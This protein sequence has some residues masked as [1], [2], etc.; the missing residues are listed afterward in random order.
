MSA[1]AG[2]DELYDDDD[3]LYD[4]DSDDEN[5]Y[6]VKCPL[7]Q[8][9]AQSFTTKALHDLIHEGLIDLNPVWQRGIVWNDPKQSHLIDSLFNNYYIPPVVFVVSRDEDG[10]EVRICVDGKQRL[11]SIQK[12]LDGQVCSLVYRRHLD[13]LFFLRYLV[14]IIIAAM[15][16]IRNSMFT[17]GNHPFNKKKFWYTT[18]SA[19][20]KNRIELSERWKFEFESKVLP[21]VEYRGVSEDQIRDI[22]QRVQMGVPLRPAERLQALSTPHADWVGQL[23]EHYIR[24]ENGISE[25][26]DWQTK[27]GADFYNVAMAVYACDYME[28]QPTPTSTTVERWLK[29]SESPEPQFRA[30]ITNMLRTFRILA[31]K[32]KYNK[33]FKTMTKRVAP[34]EFVFIC[35]ALY[36]LNE[37]TASEDE[38]AAAIL[39]FRTGIRDAVSEIRMNGTV[40]Q[41]TWPFIFALREDV[42]ASFVPNKGAASRKA[43]KRKTD[44]DEDGEYRL[45]PAK[46]QR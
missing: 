22:F 32:K 44:E 46:R 9:S 7:P 1:A 30:K 26:I 2:E 12:F 14:C 29:R 4:D 39:T 15:S 19:T 11:T 31:S 42:G 43:K 45:V 10:E 3:E 23:V 35:V 33:A 27:N 17:S 40:A 16:A 41:H 25:H 13:L 38:K 37:T 5:G 20:K 8:S 21:C 24:I 28:N 34:A 36:V 6:S 18:S